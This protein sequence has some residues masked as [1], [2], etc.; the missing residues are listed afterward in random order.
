[1]TSQAIAGNSTET[2][3]VTSIPAGVPDHDGKMPTAPFDFF[4]PP[5]PE[6]GKLISARSSLKVGKKPM[7]GIGRLI[8]ALLVGGVGF[9]F[10]YLI[11]I[12]EDD[13]SD[14]Q[15][16]TIIGAVSGVIAFLIALVL[17]KF[18]ATCSYVGDSGVATAIV[19]GNRGNPPKV[20][21][22]VFNN[23]AEL[24]ASQVRQSVNGIYTGTNYNYIWNDFDGRKIFQLKGSYNAK[25]GA[26]P[27][28]K[29]PY[30]L[31]R[32]AE[33]AWSQVLLDRADLCLKEE[34]SI[35]FQIDSKRLV[36]VG[37]GFIEFHFGGEAVRVTKD[38]IAKVTLGSG[39]FSFQHKDAKWFSRQGKFSFPYGQMANAKVFLITLDKLM[40]YRWN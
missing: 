1:M 27:K 19:R 38:D 20:E 15:M 4:I 25:K 2:A 32:M 33:I 35:P 21:L 16:F 17:A 30:H 12:Q 40:G 18:K 39:T 31:A 24:K 5:P 22:L 37:P 26:V 23:A 9:G 36:R 10:F 6:V 7:S 34:G 29:S 11:A 28:S 3:A 13:R 14:R 8:V